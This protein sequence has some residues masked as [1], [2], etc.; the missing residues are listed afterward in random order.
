MIISKPFRS[1]FNWGQNGLFKLRKF[2]FA[3]LTLG[4]GAVMGWLFMLS[5]ES[6]EVTI[7]ILVI[8][9]ILILIV[10]KPLN[11]LLVWL[12]VMAFLEQWVEIPLGAGIPDLSFSRFIVIFLG[13]IMLARAAIGEFRFKPLSLADFCIIGTTIGILLA[14]VMTM[15][16]KRAILMTISIHTV[17]L[18]I[19]FL[20]KNLVR[21]REDLVKILMAIALFGFVAG[22]YAAFEKATGQV[23]FLPKDKFVED[24]RLV[25]GESGIQLIRG[26]MGSSG[27]M[28]RIL[29][30]TIP[31]T[32]YIFLEY[33]KTFRFKALLSLMLFFQFWGIIAAMSRTPW[34]ALLSALFVMQ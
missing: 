17:P 4:L 11:G 30:F 2:L 28:G 14:T 29:A 21:T 9:L 31:V 22:A 8:A 10:R 18:V 26:L 25:R 12:F 1:I 27:T 23:L 19:Y 3:L 20:A 15:S 16:A 32:F 13:I 7:S 33:A 5:Q 24:L 6:L 34:Y